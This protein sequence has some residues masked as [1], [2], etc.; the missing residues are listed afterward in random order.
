[1]KR[2]LIITITVIVAMCALTIVNALA[3]P[4]WG[5]V[6][7]QHQQVY[8]SDVTISGGDLYILEVGF[9]PPRTYIG[10]RVR[11]LSSGG[12]VTVLA[13]VGEGQKVS[14]GKPATGE[15]SS[16]GENVE[17]TSVGDIVR[18]RVRARRS[19]YVLFAA[20]AGICALVLIIRRAR[21]EK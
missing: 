10:P 7:D 14:G 1:M 11:K 15:S 13:T 5:I 20:G 9:T 17:G 19:L 16:N 18:G 3:H 8:L 21:E 4:S 2:A 6:V 12:K